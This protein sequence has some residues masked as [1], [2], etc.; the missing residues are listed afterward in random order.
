MAST[1]CGQQKSFPISLENGTKNSDSGT[2]HVQIKSEIEDPKKYR[3]SLPSPS[4]SGVIDRR[5][6]ETARTILFTQSVE[7]QTTTVSTDDQDKIGIT[8]SGNIESSGS[9]IGKSSSGEVESRDV[10]MEDESFDRQLLMDDESSRST[11]STHDV[12]DQLQNP[13]N[14]EDQLPE[15]FIDDKIQI[16]DVTTCAE[17]LVEFFL[18]AT[19]SENKAT[20]IAEVDF[21]MLKKRDPIS[22]GELTSFATICCNGTKR[23]SSFEGHENFKAGPAGFINLT[24]T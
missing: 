7:Q 23:R 8:S 16:N 22:S 2:E 17:N 10:K 15:S 5:D 1:L 12:N 20:I 4:T 21:G 24:L 6:I 18:S 9:G 3:T 14:P 11:I 13:S 19:N